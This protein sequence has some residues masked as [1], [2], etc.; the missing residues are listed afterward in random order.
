LGLITGLPWLH[1]DRVEVEKEEKYVG[2]DVDIKEG[3]YLTY[4]EQQQQQQ[5]DG[6][7]PPPLTVASLKSRLQEERY[8]DQDSEEEEEEE[9]L[10]EEDRVGGRLVGQAGVRTTSTGDHIMAL[11]ASEKKGNGVGTNNDGDED[12]EG[13]ENVE[14]G[15][16]S[17][18]PSN[19][20][21]TT[22]PEDEEEKDDEDD[23]RN[24]LAAAMLGQP[25]FDTNLYA[26]SLLRGGKQ[27]S[28]NHSLS[29]SYIHDHKENNSQLHTQQQQQQHHH[30]HHQREDAKSTALLSSL[31][32]HL[33][34]APLLKVIPKFFRVLDCESR[35][36]LEL[37]DF[38]R[39]YRHPSIVDIK[40][41]HATWYPEADP[42]YIERARRKDMTTTQARLGFKICG[43]QVYRHGQGGYWRASKRWCKTLPETLV[44]KALLSFA[45]NEHG[46]KA[47][48]VYAA[49]GGAVEQLRALEA[50]FEMQQEFSFYSSSILLLYEGDAAGPE[51]AKVRVRLVDFAHTLI[52]EEG[53]VGGRRQVDANFLGGLRSLTQRLS[54]VSYFDHTSHLMM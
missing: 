1:N 26:P 53:E 35:V 51:D 43:M 41:G 31:P 9:E 29:P 6:P 37:E 25:V 19:I 46:L 8:Q 3:K 52:R 13:I 40:I 32:F 42:Y 5:H 4:G 27:S 16:V 23:A 33:R 12:G 36:L 18:R 47:A 2:I 34:N 49:P 22:I 45:H 54:A 21:T 15:H 30:H 39:A 48:D 7:L 20:T 38:T 28:T 44:D 14:N 50:W 11:A 24:D 17:C 10:G